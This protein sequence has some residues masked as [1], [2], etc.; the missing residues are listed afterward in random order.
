[1]TLVPLTPEQEAQ[2]KL[3]HDRGPVGYAPCTRPWPHAGPCAHPLDDPDV[4]PPTSERDAWS[5]WN[6]RRNQAHS[7]SII[8][9]ESLRSLSP[10]NRSGIIWDILEE[11]GI[12]PVELQKTPVKC[13]SCGR[14][15]NDHHVRH[16][17]VGDE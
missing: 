17:F 4:E 3:L 5:E 1:M 7:L 6:H 9:R 14:L 11:F 12:P 10:R 13:R 8:M 16:P 2:R 15:K